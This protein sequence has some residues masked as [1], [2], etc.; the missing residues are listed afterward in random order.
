MIEVN[1]DNLSSVKESEHYVLP[2][3]CSDGDPVV[4]KVR[5]FY[6]LYPTYSVWDPRI[7]D[8]WRGKKDQRRAW[9]TS[10]SAN[11]AITKERNNGC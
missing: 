3:P 8:W 10:E 11:N 4:V 9:S 2:P 1:V 6:D 7:D 5:T